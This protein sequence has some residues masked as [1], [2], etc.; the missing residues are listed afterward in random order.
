[1]ESPIGYPPPT[2]VRKRT[3]RGRVAILAVAIALVATL[4]GAWAVGRWV[5]PEASP[6][7]PT[8][9]AAPVVPAETPPE[10]MPD[11]AKTPVVTIEAP[12]ADGAQA[13]PSVDGR[14][15]NQ[16]YYVRRLADGPA[17][18]YSRTG[19]QWNYAFSC[20]SR[21]KTVEFIAVNTGS[22]GTFDKQSIVVGKVKLMMDASYSTDGGG[23]ISTSLP[24]NH[25]FF[26]AL[27][28][29]RSMEIQLYE[30]RK[31]I[32]PIGPALLRLVRDC[33]KGS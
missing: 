22:P 29:A 25:P 4:V 20:T 7:A 8:P 27:D 31:A 19:G 5:R 15:A 16:W 30:T 11:S 1:M 3:S 24:A 21:T 6:P 9:A 23:T 33:G 17:A 10:A 18:I 28:G 2:L 32:V 13:Q 12:G 14:K 26:K